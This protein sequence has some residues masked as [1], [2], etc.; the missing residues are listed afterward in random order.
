MK[1][2]NHKKGELKEDNLD[3]DD[4]EKGTRNKLH[5]EEGNKREG[6]IKK[7]AT[8]WNEDKDVAFIES[9]DFHIV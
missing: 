9:M 3:N 2:T 7:R 5:L 8:T 4:D 6:Y 1:S